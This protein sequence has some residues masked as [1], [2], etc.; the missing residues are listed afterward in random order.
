MDGLKAYNQARGYAYAL[1]KQYNRDILHDSYLV[2]YDKTGRNLFDEHRGVITK[3]VKNLHM[4]GWTRK[5]FMWRGVIYNKI[6]MLIESDVSF[7]VKQINAH[8]PFTNQNPHDLLVYAETIEL[9]RQRLSSRAQLVF[10]G[11]L[12]GYN[13][14]EIALQMAVYRQIIQYEVKQIKK[15]LKEI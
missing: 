7:G 1:D 15:V 3:T 4:S 11:L 5:T 13:Q 14:T 2:W 8:V 12:L 9:I 10:E 6:R